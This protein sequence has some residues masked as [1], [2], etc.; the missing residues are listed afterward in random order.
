M[1][2]ITPN[3]RLAKGVSLLELVVTIGIIAVWMA[4][5]FPVIRNAV[6]NAR[7]VRCMNNQRQIVTGV[8]CYSNS[9]DSKYPE[10]VATIGI[11][12][13][14]W[15]WQEPTMLTGCEKRRPNIHRS[16]SE[17][18]QS[19]IENAEVM[20]CP[21]APGKYKYLQKAWDAG[22]DWDNPETPQL[23]DP[24]IGTYCF[25]WSYIGFL[26]GRKL[27]FN[28][29]MNALGEPGQSSLL[30]T[31]YFGFGHW[32]NRTVY[33]DYNAYGSSER[34]AGTSITPGTSVSLDF[35]SRRGRAGDES[36]GLENLKVNLHA[37]YTDMHVERYTPKDAIPMKVAITSDGSVPYPDDLGPGQF[38]LPRNAL[39]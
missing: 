8:I 19:Y 25:Y 35:W 34:F 20:F 26:P 28:G 7:A 22:D 17:Y 21:S 13:G 9:N 38:Y 23:Q 37:C 10:S 11:E 15:N 6:S 3:D 39:P 2:Q 24:V 29:P 33:G 14:Y 12:G 1:T 36:T 27:P 18:L 32:R 31:D 4:L 5:M 30:V 16:V